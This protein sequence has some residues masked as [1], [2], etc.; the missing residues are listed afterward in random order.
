M[1]KKKKRKSI[2]FD[3][4][5]YEFLSNHDN[6]SA[7][8]RDL[9][10]QYRTDGNREKAA[11]KL[12]QQQKQRELES[13]REDVNRL[14]NDLE[15]ITELLQEV[16]DVES[17]QWDNAVSALENTPK[18]PDNPAVENWADKLGLTPTAL[19]EQLPEDGR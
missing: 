10:E 5:N 7:L 11:L 17:E 13:S 3:E 12:R 18:E 6:A 1:S 2:T 8:V 14:E 15:E 4:D 9:V 16:K 19:I